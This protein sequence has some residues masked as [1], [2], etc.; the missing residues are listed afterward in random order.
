MRVS[1]KMSRIQVRLWSDACRSS[2]RARARMPETPPPSCRQRRRL[3]RTSLVPCVAGSLGLT[4]ARC[5]CATGSLKLAGEVG[6]AA[7]A[8]TTT[9]TTITTS[10]TIAATTVIIAAAVAATITNTIA[11]TIAA[12]AAT[13][14]ATIATTIATTIAASRAAFYCRYLHGM[15]LLGRL[16]VSSGLQVAAVFDHAGMVL[17]GC[18]VASADCL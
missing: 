14:A 1:R 17:M 8:T 15:G 4:P 7:I 16:H 2:T 6:M 12:I 9:I 3:L 13:I 5:L 10:T 11:T 18:G